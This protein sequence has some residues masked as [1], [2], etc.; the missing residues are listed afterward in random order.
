MIGDE[1]GKINAYIQK[2][3]TAILDGQELT[4]R[5]I[6]T[7]SWRCIAQAW[8]RVG[9]VIPFTREQRPLLFWFTIAIAIGGGASKLISTLI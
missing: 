4:N 5:P 1:Q 2:H 8:A 9:G 3:R 6:S 7:H